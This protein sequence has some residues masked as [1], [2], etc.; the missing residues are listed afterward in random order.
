M[1]IR[2]ATDEDLQQVAAVHTAS[3]LDL[4]AQRYSVVQLAHWKDALRQGG[5]AALLATREF[6]V[7]EENGALLGFGVLDLSESLINATYV[8]PE[9][10][11][12][13]VGRR[14]VQAM[15]TI[16]RQQGVT[17]L[18]LNSTL[19]AVP[20]Y[21]S[22]GYLQEGLSSN[23]LPT[24]VE[25]PCVVMTKDLATE[26][27]AAQQS[28]SHPLW[29][30]RLTGLPT[31]RDLSQCLPVAETW[32]LW[33]DI[34]GLIWIN[35]QFGFE[36]GH[37]AV[38]SIAGALRAL[39]E[40]IGASLFRV[41]GDEF[42]ALLHNVDQTTAVTLADGAVRAIDSLEI[43]YRRSDRPSSNHLQI[44]IAVLRVGPESLRQSIGEHSLGDPIHEL[45]ANA[46]Y[47]GKLRR[48][49]LAGIVVTLAEK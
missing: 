43:P 19:N 30:S 25:L 11:R 22:L 39:L 40:P 36:R 38:A 14:L 42:L 4:C 5:Y 21:E 33:I 7:A 35:D 18:H 49:G 24:G 45:A 17:R 26:R 12:R 37:Q 8:S 20:F 9:V 28:F 41:A 13:G 44:N 1:N 3:I 10:T 34:D 47:A 2:R 16:A 31:H 29:S 32:A 27:Q 15:E 6:L 48:N 46:V 23:R